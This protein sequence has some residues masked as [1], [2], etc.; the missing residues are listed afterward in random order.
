MANQPQYL[1]VNWVDGMKINKH[2]FADEQNARMQEQSFATG[3]HITAVNYGLLPPV[4]GEHSP[5]NLYI[6]LDNQQQVN[7]NLLYCRAI[8]PG[9]Y[10]I[11]IE[12]ETGNDS[13]D[14][15][16]KIS[17][18]SVPFA[19]LKGKANTY[20][21][22]LAVN[23]YKRIPAGN[24]APD[25]QP[26]RIPYTMPHYSLSILAEDNL[27]NK[28]PGLFQLVIGKFYINEQ[29]IE[30]D[31]NYIPPCV[32][33]S[34]H[35]ELIDV[36]AGMESF[37]SKME[38]YST[39]ILQKIIL[40]KQQNELAQIVQVI[41]QNMLQYTNSHAMVYRWSMLHEP[42]LHMLSVVASMARVLKNTLDQ[43][44]G[45]G[46][47][48]LINYFMEWCDLNQG[49]LENLI[50]NLTTHKYV[51]EDINATVEITAA[52]TKSISSLF[53]NLSRLEYIGKKKDANIFVKEE[54]V[55]SDYPELEIKKRR[56][57]LAD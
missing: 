7:V 9:G 24:A 43:Y 55:K 29:N 11:H 48:E 38:L 44:V 47:E 57:F 14:V 17:G 37:I 26:P 23:P 25:E 3:A 1:P 56:S 33:S 5:I 10:V 21:V 4:A 22:V 19:Q 27:Q 20:F 51:H 12:Q 35:P 2:H 40:K 30:V 49:E 13:V 39:Q 28:K 50:T 54:M 8:T 41:C 16:E 45:S 46:K 15:S 36:F 42:P 31:E 53:H 32:T 52:F 34:S 18:L 6:N